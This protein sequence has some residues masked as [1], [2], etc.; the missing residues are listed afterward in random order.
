MAPSVPNS[1]LNR[2]SGAHAPTPRDTFRGS[3]PAS[4]QSGDGRQGLSF[5]VEWLE[6]A[7]QVAALESEW[8]ELEARVYSRMA[9]GSFDYLFPWYCHMPLSQGAPLVGVAR[10]NGHVVGI[11]PLA[12]R[13]ATL[14]RVPLR[15]IDSAGHDGDVG[16]I[17][18]TPDEGS[19]F[20]SLLESL[21]ER[22]GFDAAILTGVTPGTWLDQAIRSVASRAG[23]SLEEIDYRYATVDLRQGFDAYLEG[24]NSKKRGNLRRR[25]KRA[26]SMGGTTLDRIN[27]P[28]D[29]ATLSRYLDRVFGLY[30]RSWKA[31]DGEAIQ[32]YHRRFY[33]DVA[34]RF[35]ARSMLDLSILQV[36]G[37]DA[38]F[39]LGLRERD[40]FYDVTISYDEEFAPVS[41][42]ML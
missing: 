3:P 10:R 14:G 26:D 4:S 11:A 32:E 16:E 21:F 1:P 42:G 28:V 23:R 15:R 2:T 7:H 34:E 8:R 39:I 31:A 13:D 36:G 40:T 12:R 24:L 38:A 35:N 17:L 18:F 9:F 5:H 30:E 29:R 27:R 25:Q 6:S 22:G 33:V 41:P 20:E 19:A 37:R